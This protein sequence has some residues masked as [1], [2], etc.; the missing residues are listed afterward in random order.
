MPI[1][2]TTQAGES[3]VAGHPTTKVA[4]APARTDVARAGELRGGTSSA[5]AS[6]AEETISRPP[7]D[8]V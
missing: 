4:D 5:V 6:A 1:F 8:L 3:T 7:R 2:L